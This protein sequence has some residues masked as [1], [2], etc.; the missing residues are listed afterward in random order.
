MTKEELKNLIDT[1]IKENGGGEI[2]ASDLHT[3]LSELASNNNSTPNNV[4]ELKVDM[5]ECTPDNQPQYLEAEWEPIKITKSNMHNFSQIKIM[6]YNMIQNMGSM[7]AIQSS[8]YVYSWLIFIH[9]D[10]CSEGTFE[11]IKQSL[12]EEYEC[13]VGDCCLFIAIGYNGVI[14]V[15][16]NG[17]I[18]KALAYNITY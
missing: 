17:D 6:Y 1:K 13:Q 4:I 16:R 11:F 12:E 2:T 7:Q 15:N 8:S 3:I 10:D 14:A 18:V 5:T 9:E